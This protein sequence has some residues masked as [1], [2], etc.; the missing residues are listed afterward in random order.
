MQERNSGVPL[1]KFPGMRQT[2]TALREARGFL[3]STNGS[4]SHRQA[5]PELTQRA[6]PPSSAGSSRC[7]RRDPTVPERLLGPDS[8]TSTAWAT[9]TSLP[10]NG[11]PTSSRHRGTCT[12]STES[13]VTGTTCFARVPRLGQRTPQTFPH[14]CDMQFVPASTV[15]QR[16]KRWVFDARRTSRDGVVKAL[17]PTEAARFAIAAKQGT[18]SNRSHTRH[19]RFEASRIPPPARSSRSSSQELVVGD[20]H[21]PRRRGNSLRRER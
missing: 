19:Q 10:G 15:G 6:I 18:A 17:N 3:L 9:C 12:A 13:K 16:C 11:P 1:P 8:G 7:M 21:G 4:T 20:A 14:S 2:R 5:R